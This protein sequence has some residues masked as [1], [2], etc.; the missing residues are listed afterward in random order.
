LETASGRA[1]ALLAVGDH[2][3][4][5]CYVDNKGVE[6]FDY[7]L[8]SKVL[9]PNDWDPQAEVFPLDIDAEWAGIPKPDGWTYPKAYI[10]AKNNGEWEAV[11]REYKEHYKIPFFGPSPNRRV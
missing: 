6:P 4:G 11:T 3:Q 10:D 5:Q 8:L 1:P 9:H 7:R 2:N